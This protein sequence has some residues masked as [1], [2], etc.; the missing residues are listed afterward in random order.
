[1]LIDFSS[2]PQEM[3]VLRIASNLLTILLVSRSTEKIIIK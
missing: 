3:R 2:S 1:V